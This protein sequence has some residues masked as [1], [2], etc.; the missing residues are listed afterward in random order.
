MIMLCGLQEC[1]GPAQQISAFKIVISLE[2]KMHE[3]HDALYY[4][5]LIFIALWFIIKY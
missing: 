2:I 1:N 4:Y 3:H 5:S